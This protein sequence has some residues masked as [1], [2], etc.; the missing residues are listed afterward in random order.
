M[1]AFR[2]FDP[3]FAPRM[4]SPAAAG[5]QP[6]IEGLQVG[7]VIRALNAIPAREGGS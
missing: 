3:L 7:S 2:T 4:P 6:R 5:V 1:T